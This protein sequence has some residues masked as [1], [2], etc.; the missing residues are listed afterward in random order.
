MANTL[1]SFFIHKIII[2][3]GLSGQDEARIDSTFIIHIRYKFDNIV[4]GLSNGDQH[5]VI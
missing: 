1:Y 2:S 5:E 4:S 3:I